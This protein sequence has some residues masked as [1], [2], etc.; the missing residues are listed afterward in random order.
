MSV[1]S[2]AF[3]VLLAPAI[4]SAQSLAELQTLVTPQSL[5]LSSD[6]SHLWYKL[7]EEWW[8]V[9]TGL[10]PRPTRAEKPAAA[11]KQ[12]PPAIS[13]TGRLS[14]PRRSPDEKKVAYLDAESPYG[15]LLLYCLCRDAGPNGKASP[16]SRMPI[17][18]F[19]W[20][21]D[22]NSLWVIGAVGADEPVGRLKF[23]GSLERVSEGPAMRRLG[24]L[25]A[26]NDILIW[27]QSDGSKYGT[28]WVRDKAGAS[29]ALVEPNPQTAKWNIGVQ[30]V[31]RWKNAAG[32]ELQGVLARPKSGA[33]LPLI[34][35]PYSSWRNRFLN[36]PVLGNYFF[37][38]EGFAVFFPD[39]R[40]P[41]TF[42]A[43]SFGDSY[44]GSSKDRDP[45]EVLTDDVMSGV[46]ELV[47][48][49]IA[50]PGRLF[51]YS[52]SNG[53]SA[54]NQLLTQ[55][56]AFRA[57]LSLG[58]VSDWLGYYQERRPLG[59]KTIPGF[60]GGREPEDNM[61]LYRRISPIYQVDRITTP[62]LLVAGEKDTR[63]PDTLRF[64]EALR[65]AGRPVTLIKYPGEGHGISDPALAEQHVRRAM[66]FF[67]AA[68]TPS[69]QPAR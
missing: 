31:V 36:I 56:Q 45:V 49:G 2:K 60:L 48:R 15:P 4:C 26:A 46:N 54:V 1:V 63:F 42:P 27:V 19:Q 20:A 62:L 58:G 32:E 43:V 16:L 38:K 61:E 69:P 9:G 5:Q 13:G 6:G 50:D 35:D 66:D 3:V 53:A 65:K 17:M 18:D 55:T 28:I 7:G 37:V 11:P 51:L 8:Q 14:K 22:S 57:A 68:S 25:L 40:A 12:N 21:Q 30:E 67:Q 33:R 23:D 44:V 59:D 29:R 24:G 41:H 34:V 10:N 47:R 52:F 39:H 64:Y